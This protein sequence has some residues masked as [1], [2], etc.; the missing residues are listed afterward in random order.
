MPV[1]VGSFAGSSPAVG[2]SHPLSAS[3]SESL[4]SLGRVNEPGLGSS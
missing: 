2:C 3:S 1:I 4:T